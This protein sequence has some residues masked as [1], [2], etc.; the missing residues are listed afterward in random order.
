M[1]LLRSLS[2]LVLA[3]SAASAHASSSGVVISQAYGAGGNSGAAYTHDFVELFNAGS[4]PVNIGGWSIQYASAAGTG[5]FA[6][7]TPFAL[8]AATLQP[9]QYFLVRF[10]GGLN[11]TALPTPDAAIAGT[12]P[13][14]SGSDGKIALVDGTTGLACNGGSSVCSAAQLAQII[15]LVGYGTANFF[16]GS[17]APKLSSTTAAMRAAQGCTDTDNNSADFGAVAPAPRN[18]ASPLNACGGGG[19]NQPIAASC[20]A[21]SVPAGSAGTATVTASDADSVVNALAIVGTAPAGI[22]IGSVTPAAAEGGIA[23]ATIDIG[24]GV[25]AGSHA[26]TLQWS[27]D[28][29]QTAQ[30]TL[31]IAVSGMTPIYGIQGSG[32][33]SPLAGRIVNTGGVVTKL[34]SNGFFMQDPNGDNDP[35]TSDGIFVFTGTAPTVSVGQRVQLSATVAEFNTGAASNA[36][37]AAHP[38]TELVS[39]SGI[40]VLGSGYA[41]GPVSVVLPEAVNDDLERFEGMLVTL[42]GPLTANQNYFQGRY[43]QVTLASGG[44]LETPTNRHPAGPDAQALADEN[45]RRRILLDDGTTLQNPNPT[46]YIGAD[47]TL[48]AGDTVEAVTGVIDYGLAT[49]SN[50]GFGDYKIHPTAALAFT[51]ANA[52]KLAPDAVGG[53]VTV[54][55]AN[56]LNYF[57]T[58]TDGNTAGGQAGQGCTLGGATAAANCRGAS[59]AAEFAR[60]RAKI[61]EAVA[62]LGADVVG[63]MEIQNNGSV[64]VQNLVDGLNVKLGAGTYAAVPDPATG[65]GTDAIKVAMI[66]RPAR[67]SRV[68]ASLSDT[69]AIHNRPPLAQTF[70]AVNGERFTVVVNHFKSKSC[71]DAAG[72]DLDQND[73]QG[74]YNHRRVQQ[75]QALRGFVA[76]L[77]ATSGS[78]DVLLIG[79]FNAYAKE[80]PMLDLTDNG[81]VDQVGRFNAFGYSYVF[82]GAAGRLDQALATP[83]LSAKVVGATEWHVN[84]DE[85]SVIDYNLEFKQP[86]CATCGPDYYSATPYR[87]SDH[88][89]VVVGLNLTH[90]IAG[91]A[92]RETITGTPGDDVIT[93]GAGADTLSGGA[94]SDVFVY[95]SMRDAAD[96]IT[97]FA[98]GIDRIDLSALLRSIGASASMALADGVV[99]IVASGPSALVQIDADGSAGPGAPRTL[100]TLRN[101][102]AD[103]VDAARDLILQ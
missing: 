47:N 36:D 51:R 99:R 79:D 100:V 56:V 24:A 78:N 48:R 10:A 58:F 102:G 70:A 18:T 72:A 19:V 6:A 91:T 73:L 5:N 14:F 89:P 28:E 63:L 92:A 17:A 44:R 66:Y 69:A 7:N 82:D 101:T 94:G 84:A 87:S 52:R 35:L 76:G 39:P 34:V 65:T 46:P 77:Q 86:A 40:T 80:D 2:G 21:A 45:A 55:S 41:I 11:G 50:T 4:T 22:T 95:A 31:N 74:C 38:V 12:S 75:A 96:T 20:P 43:G 49:S 90:A 71:T 85:P 29:A 23:V 33:T 59:N 93:G 8:P 3:L 9:G 27:N 54:A 88:D 13:N 42:V 98:P 37:T 57:T 103:A 61:V 30:C 25:A 53:N 67:V 15:D 60:Q 16:E 62:A 83:S 26:L 1:N 97:D 68:G 32:A 81:L 64:A